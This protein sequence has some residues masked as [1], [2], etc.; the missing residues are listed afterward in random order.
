MRIFS[1]AAPLAVSRGSAKPQAGR[2]AKHFSPFLWNTCDFHDI[3]KLSPRKLARYRAGKVAA[4]V[5]KIAIIPT[6]LT[7]GNGVCGFAAIAMASKII[8]IDPAAANDLDNFYLSLAGWLILAAMLFDALDGYVA[9]LSKSASNFGGQL[10]SLCDAISFGVAPAFILLRLGQSWSDRPLIGKTFVTV[11][12]LYMVCTLLRLARFNVENTPDPA[13]HK[14]FRGL[15]S[16]G[17]AGCLASL[18][19]LYGEFPGKIALLQ[20][21]FGGDWAPLDGTHLRMAI[22]VWALLG[23]LAIALLMV[24]RV[25]YP[26][27]T[28]QVLRGRRHFSH[29][30]QVVLFAFVI[31]LIRELAL[32]L[33]FWIYALGIP[34][35][36]Q[37]A[38]HFRRN[39]NLGSRFEDTPLPHSPGGR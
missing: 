4:E 8:R 15:P 28:K 13:S 22:I 19:I 37:V 23:A 38:R 30:V 9:R 14:R 25:P 21:E 35:R 6:L 10:D 39:Q 1:P 36:Y 26:H 7:L 29:L 11:A 32:V 2:P 17:A 18:A 20:R 5:K 3:F 27:V 16:P 31:I 24:S 12:T 34:A 33:L